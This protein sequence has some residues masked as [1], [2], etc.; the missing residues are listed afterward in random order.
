MIDDG[1]PVERDEIAD[2]F[3]VG[4]I[5]LALDHPRRI[6]VDTDDGEIVDIEC[7]MVI[8][9]HLDPGGVARPAP[10]ADPDIHRQARRAAPNIDHGKKI[11]L[12]D[13]LIGHWA[14]I[15]HWRDASTTW[16]DPAAP[17][18]RRDTHWPGSSPSAARAA[19]C[20]ALR[21]RLSISTRS[22]RTSRKPS[23]I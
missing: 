17:P 2:L 15:A 9:L 6:L 21:R 10:R 7:L 3:E 8:E 1:S 22:D 20:S 16:D 14:S 4:G 18:T 5:E 13:D 11:V 19:L 23:R 12:G